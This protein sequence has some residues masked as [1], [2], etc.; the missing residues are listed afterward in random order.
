[1]TSRPTS[2]TARTP[3]ATDSITTSRGPGTSTANERA[4]QGDPGVGH[5]LLSLIVALLATAAVGLLAYL[6]GFDIVWE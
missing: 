2:M 4:N 1:M 6:V 3:A 5:S